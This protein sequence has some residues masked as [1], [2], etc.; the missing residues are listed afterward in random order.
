MKSLFLSA[1][2]LVCV[3][4]ANAQHEYAPVQEHKI[5]YKDWTY[6]SVHD[7]SEMN[8]RDFTKGKKLVMVVYF[9]AWCGNWKLAAPVAQKFYDKYKAGNRGDH[10]S[11]SRRRPVAPLRA[12]RELSREHVLHRSGRAGVRG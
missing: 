1:I 12:L 7:G 5:K 9:A 4:F 10:T 11:D 6:K 8:L 2:L 3:T